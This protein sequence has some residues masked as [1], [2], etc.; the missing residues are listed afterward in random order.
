MVKYEAWWL[1]SHSLNVHYTNTRLPDASPYRLG[2]V[3][4]SSSE[5]KFPKKPMT[6]HCTFKSNPAF[7]SQTYKKP[8]YPD[9]ALE[10]N[11][12][13]LDLNG[14]E[15][16]K[17][18]M[19]IWFQNGRLHAGALHHVPHFSPPGWSMITMFIETNN[20]SL[21]FNQRRTE[22]WIFYKLWKEKSG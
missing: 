19:A 21:D 2:S 3:C 4:L 17:K 18:E 15:T 20:F 9:L 11:P 8:Y 10:K 1:D 13:H 16:V 12:V 14:L 7:K 6:L 22:P 5:L